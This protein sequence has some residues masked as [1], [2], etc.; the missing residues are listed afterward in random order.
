MGVNKPVYVAGLERGVRP[1]GDW[2]IIIA[3]S[4]C[5]IPWISS[6][7]PGTALARCKRAESSLAT[8]SLIRLDLPEPDTP[9]TTTN[10]PSG[11]STSRFCRLFSRAPLISSDFPLLDRRFLGTA[12]FFSPRKYWPVILCLVLATSAGVP[13]ATI[14]PP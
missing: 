4:R 2:S 8:M 5:L 9:L 1:I 7:L 3:L 6:C 12:I 11:I 10:W 14:S 13:R